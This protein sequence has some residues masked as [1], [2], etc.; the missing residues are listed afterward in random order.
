[1]KGLFIVL[2][3]VLSLVGCKKD[4][5]QVVAKAATTDSSSDTPTS[6]TDVP[7]TTPGTAAGTGTATA[8]GTAATTDTATTTVDSAAPAGTTITLNSGASSTVAASINVA[9]IATDNVGVTGLFLS[10]TNTAPAADNSGWVTVASTASYSDNQSY[11]LSST[12][13]NKTLYLW[14]KDAAGNISAGAQG[15]ILLTSNWGNQFGSAGSETVFDIAAD[16][17]G[18]VYVV[19]HTTGDLD[20]NTNHGFTD[21]FISKFDRTGTRL[22]TKQPGTAAFDGAAAA[23]VDSQ[24]NLY[25]AGTTSGGLDGNTLVGGASDLFISKY[26]PDGQLVWTKQPGTSG[27]EEVYGLDIDPQDNVVATG[28]TT[29]ALDSNAYQGSNDLFVTKY[30]TDG[31]FVWTKQSGADNDIG[32]AVAIAQNGNIYVS[33]YSTGNFE[34]NTNANLG[35]PDIFISKYDSAGAPVWS[36][37]IGGTGQDN[38]FDLVV[39]SSENI[40]LTGQTNGALS[41]ANAGGYDL[42]VTKLDASGT[43]LWTKQD[44]S[45]ANDAGNRLALDGAGNLWIVG[46]ATAAVDGTTYQSGVD[47]LVSKYDADGNSLLTKHLGTTVNDYGRGV[48]FDTSG[49]LL[50]GGNTTGTFTG[51][52][53]AG[54]D[55]LFILK[56]PLGYMP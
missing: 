25:V 3:V 30:D 22:W 18:N 11:T 34:G 42:F 33:G 35:V 43:V 36:K 28:Y 13:G 19:G 14:V 41:G 53:T 5:G 39:D 40:Y 45:T 51:E 23:E 46:E 38:G 31:N 2:L 21:I 50:I 26:S 8:T 48:T 15:N 54:S 24:G 49:N 29:G 6:T 56:N 10:E 27:S 52:T 44:G 1:M 47:A 4:Q 16:Q 12:E 17:Q 37:L 32:N 7:T 20:G 55:D 9:I